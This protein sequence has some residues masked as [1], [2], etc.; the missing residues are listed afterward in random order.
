MTRDPVSSLTFECAYLAR[1]WNTGDGRE[2]EEELDME[3]F[4]W[5]GLLIED[6]EEEAMY[7]SD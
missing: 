3:E 5:H 6:D 2:H 1:S 4:S 7:H